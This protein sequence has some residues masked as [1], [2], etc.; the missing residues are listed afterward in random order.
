M[1]KKVS[2]LRTS[3][4]IYL[5]FKRLIDI[6]GSILGIVVCFILLWWWVIIVNAIVTKGHPFFL[7]Y[8]VGKN[9]K[10]FKLIKFRSVKLKY[11]SDFT[12]EVTYLTDDMLTKF[13]RFLRN[14]SIDETPQL[15]NIL[16][17]KMSFVGPRP[18]LVDP[19]GYTEDTSTLDISE[20]NHST[21]VI[22]R[23]NHSVELKP[24]L[25]G[26]AQILDRNVTS[27][28][29]RGNNDGIYFQKFNLWM[30]TKIFF[31]TILHI[32]GLAKGK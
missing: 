19:D 14:T 8:R 3:Q 24:G 30:D 6:F 18:V 5:P 25:T 12:S 28:I 22:R 29:E 9:E 16:L 31:F 32:F 11:S 27:P 15:I 23:E 1:S 10:P 17:G 20:S 2:H 4:K 7:Q 26:Y 13:G 21:L